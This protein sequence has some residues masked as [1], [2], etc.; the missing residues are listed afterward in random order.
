MTS[1]TIVQLTN[2]PGYHK[3]ISLFF[4]DDLVFSF[5]HDTSFFPPTAQQGTRSSVSTRSSGSSRTSG[6]SKFN[7]QFDLDITTQWEFASQ[8]QAIHIDVHTRC[9]FGNIQEYLTD[10]HQHTLS[11]APVYF[12]TTS[13]K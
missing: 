7:K 4:V 2:K 3:L 10:I 11:T 5:H 12:Y 9:V 6:S 13:Y 8:E 1:P